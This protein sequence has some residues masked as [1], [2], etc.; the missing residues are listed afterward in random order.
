MKTFL[1][2]IVTLV[3]CGCQP[4][5]EGPHPQAERIEKCVE[6]FERSYYLQTFDLAGPPVSRAKLVEGCTWRVEEGRTFV[7]EDWNT[8]DWR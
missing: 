3:L 5:P 4:A 6:H 7:L 1:I 8:A 2:M